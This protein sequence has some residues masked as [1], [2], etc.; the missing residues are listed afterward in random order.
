MRLTRHTDYA[1]RVLLQAASLPGQRLSIA[2][3][4]ETH[5]ISKNHAMKV[6]NLLAR[7]GLLATVRGR[8]GGLMLGRPAEDIRLGEV[9]RLTEPELQAADCAT[10]V[11]RTS[12]GLTLVLGAAM[13]AFLKVL[14][15]TTLADVAKDSRWPAAGVAA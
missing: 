8:G 7:H 1:L 6:V 15:D 2:G 5:G 11:L 13:A 9:V 14:D 4:A 12:C 10:C 3:V